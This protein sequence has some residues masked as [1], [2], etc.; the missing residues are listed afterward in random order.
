MNGRELGLGGYMDIGL[1][2]TM[3]DLFVN[4]IGA[5]VFALIGFFS[6]RKGSAGKIAMQFVPRLLEE[7][8]QE[9]QDQRE[10]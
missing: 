4:F 7:E 2:D 10:Y 9:E 8:K 5:L 3:E 6:T 1:Y